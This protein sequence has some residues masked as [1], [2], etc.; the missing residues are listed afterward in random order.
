MIYIKI[1]IGLTT[2]SQLLI[3]FLQFGNTQKN[4]Y[5]YLNYIS[6]IISINLL[7]YLKISILKL[8]LLY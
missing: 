4:L 8:F 1:N 2:I 6:S 5:L 3:W 7:A